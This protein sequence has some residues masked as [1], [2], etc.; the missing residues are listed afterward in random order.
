MQGLP[1]LRRN[2]VRF[3]APD[4]SIHDVP[5]K[6]LNQA[7]SIDPQLTLLENAALKEHDRQVMRTFRYLVIAAQDL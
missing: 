1:P 7:L 4:K 6:H 5:A 3:Q 2:Y